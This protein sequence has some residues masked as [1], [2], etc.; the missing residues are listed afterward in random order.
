MIKVS[1]GHLCQEGGMEEYQNQSEAHPAQ[2]Q[3]VDCLGAN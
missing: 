2:R 3:E 1:D